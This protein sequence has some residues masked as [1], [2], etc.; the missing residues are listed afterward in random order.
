MTTTTLSAEHFLEDNLDTILNKPQA[1]WEYVRCFHATR[2]PDKEL[3]CLRGVKLPTE[4]SLG[5]LLYGLGIERVSRERLRQVIDE[6]GRSVFVH[7]S[8][9]FLRNQC[10]FLSCGAEKI[11]KYVNDVC[12]ERW[13]SVQEYL[14][15]WK[16]YLFKL[17]IPI[18]YFEKD[19]LWRDL[20]NCSQE[21]LQT[22]IEEV[23]ITLESPS[24]IPPEFIEDVCDI[25]EAKA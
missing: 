16:P 11:R 17:K 9:L 1:H 4:D 2:L 25:E 12:P 18:T 13:D 20:E 10:D 7:V 3:I 15:A 6:N 19:E 21:L 24:D 5:E 22:S 23:D 14:A 8:E